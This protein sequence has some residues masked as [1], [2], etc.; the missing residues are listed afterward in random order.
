MFWKYSTAFIVRLPVITQFDWSVRGQ[1]FP[2]FPVPI[3]MQKSYNKS[4]IA[5][6]QVGQ[7]GEIFRIAFPVMQQY[8]YM[9]S[10]GKLQ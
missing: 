7:Y 10:T 9:Y 6:P 2:L 3:V 4:I 1:Y 5:I 8:S